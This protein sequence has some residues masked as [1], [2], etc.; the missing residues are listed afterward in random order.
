MMT[1]EVRRDQAV[2]VIGSKSTESSVEAVKYLSG[3]AD[4]RRV[5]GG[6]AEARTAMILARLKRIIKAH[7]GAIRAD[8]DRDT[9]CTLTLTLPISR[10]PVRGHT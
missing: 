3:P 6:L 1:V 4:L 7:R 5:K 9:A 2:I 10:R 8:T